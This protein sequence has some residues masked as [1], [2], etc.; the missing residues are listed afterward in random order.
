MNDAPLPLV[1]VIVPTKN[2]ANTLEICLESVQTQTY[3]HVEVIIVDNHSTD[4][5]QGIAAR[6]GELHIRGPERSAQKNWG[7]KQSKGAYLLFLDSDCELE[8]N[9]VKE[10]VSLCQ[11]GVS[12]VMIP[13]EHIG[14]G[15]W[16]AVKKL[17]RRCYLGDDSLEAP[18]FFEKTAFQAINGFDEELVGGEDWDIARR[19]RESGYAVGRSLA[20]LKHHIGHWKFGKELKKRF[21]YGRTMKTYLQKNRSSAIRKIPF[22]RSAYLR[23]WRLLVSH[24]FLALGLFV[25]KFLETMFVGTGVMVAYFLG[26]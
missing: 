19:M 17:E 2:S 12:G 8:S 16:A 10:C 13:M 7:S 14:R 1:S 3:P 9:V 6:Y 24:P 11:E 4:S 26:S 23:N 15:F 5:T 21:Y 22:F 20:G 18:W 25:L